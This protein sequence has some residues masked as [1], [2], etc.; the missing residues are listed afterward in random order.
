[1]RDEE[2]S[3]ID[4]KRSCDISFD[5]AGI[6]ATIYIRSYKDKIKVSF[7]DPKTHGEAKEPCFVFMKHEDYF[8]ED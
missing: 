1:M 5:D 6:D 3:T 2:F 4:Q 8:N 7:T